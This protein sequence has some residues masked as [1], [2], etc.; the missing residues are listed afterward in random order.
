MQRI[1]SASRLQNLFTACLAIA[2]LCPAS[3]AGP[4]GERHL[5]ASNP[6][7]SLRDVDHRNVVRITVWYPASFRSK[8]QSLDIGEPG[9]PLFRVGKAAPDA[10]FGD[11]KL[12]PVVLFSHGFGGSARMMAW[13]TTALARVGYIVVAVDHPG[14]NSADKMTTAGAILF[15]DR[16]DDLAA[17]LALVESDPII[18]PHLDLMRIAVAGFSAGGFTALISAGAKV[19]LNRFRTFCRDNPSDGV[20]RPQKEFAVTMDEAEEAWKSPT[21]AAEADHA[22]DD[23][24]ILGVR[25]VF[26]IAPA[27]IQALTPESLEG[28]RVPVAII[29][30]N[31]DEVA[32]PDTNGLVADRDIPFSRLKVLRD[33]G[34]YDFLS[35]CTPAGVATV[36]ICTAKVPQDQTHQSTID[37]AR[38]FLK[39]V[40]GKP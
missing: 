11:S 35:T 30:G 17:A 13:F 23:H 40:F 20:C 32:G 37:F 16:A 10:P 27:I 29:L 34:H 14:N 33:V 4:V 8:E 39:R 5:Q 9:K 6:T 22:G 31:A 18:G 19:D 21:L 38:A 25:A 24:S 28:I 15:W 26:A 7:A 12:R 1:S 3:Y 2:L 36:P